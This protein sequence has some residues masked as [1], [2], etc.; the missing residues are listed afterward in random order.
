MSKHLL[1][2]AVVRKAKSQAKAYRLFDG[3]GLAL[4]VAP[5]GAKSWQF[6]YRLHGKPQTFTV[7]KYPTFSLAEARL[8][9]E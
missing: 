4:R 1:T 3:E 9:A 7:G 8:R 5:T 2:D 6:R